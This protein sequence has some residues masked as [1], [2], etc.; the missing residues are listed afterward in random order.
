MRSLALLAAAVCVAACSPARAPTG[1]APPPNGAMHDAASPDP[2]VTSFA[3]I[4]GCREK[5]RTDWQ[6]TSNPS[7]ANLAQLEQTFS[8]LTGV[9]VPTPK[10]LFFPGDLVLGLD[11]STLGGQLEAWA[12]LYLRHPSGIAKRIELV[13]IMGNH[14]S[15]ISSGPGTPELPSAASDALFGAWLTAHHFDSHG[16]NGPRNV[17]PNL[18]ALADD[19]SKLTYSFD[20]GPVHFVVMDTDSLTTTPDPKTGST[21]IG[22]VPYAWLKSDLS[23]AQA[24]DATRAIFLFGHKPLVRFANGRP[25][26]DS[27]VINLAMNAKVSDLIDGTPKFK[28]YFTS[29]DHLWYAQALPG[30]RGA[31]QVISGNGGSPVEKTWDDPHYGFTVVRLYASGRVGVV[32]YFRPVPSPYDAPA[33]EPARPQ[34]ELTIAY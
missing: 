33:T 16:G 13:P 15:L 23:A 32:P 19:E 18:D 14:E 4:G 28:G 21:Q 27:D 2:L 20:D 25:P 8:D 17:P 31:V 1:T 34:P 5:D 30:K 6:R 12:D 26:R 7:S 9:V 24:R 29:H 22:W 10:Y 11:A 3:W